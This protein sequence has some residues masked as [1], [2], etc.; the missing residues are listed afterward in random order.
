[1]SIE[2][3]LLTLERID[4][5]HLKEVWLLHLSRDNAADDFKRRVQEL[6]GCEVYVAS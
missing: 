1:M 4:R 5:S 6:C 3:A 2:T